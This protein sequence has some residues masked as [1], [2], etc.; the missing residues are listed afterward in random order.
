MAKRKSSKKTHLQEGWAIYLRTSSN[1][2]QNPKNSQDRQ[3]TRIMQ[4]LIVNSGLPVIAE[5]SDVETGKEVARPGY[6]KMLEDARDGKFSCIAVENTERFSRDD[7]EGLR[8]I[9]EL[10]GY[11]INVRFA[12]YASIDPLHHDQRLIIS[13]SFSIARGESERN[14][15]RSSGGIEAK[16]RTGMQTGKAVNGY[17]NV[18]ESLSGIDKVIEGPTRNTIKDDPE[19]WHVWREAWD[20]LLTARYSFKQICM[21]LH[22]RGYKRK[23]GR[24][25]IYIN[26]NGELADAS[27]TLSN[28][29]HN[30][31]YAGWVVSKT[32]GIF[33]KQIRGN[34]K[35]VVSD[36]EF[37]HFGI[38][39][40]RMVSS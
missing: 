16:Q 15:Q 19:T 34:W 6:Q 2:T 24:P 35:P 4:N 21:E 18:Q 1:E 37:E 28:I 25:F 5:Y 23:S 10:D 33:Y 27:A 14:S 20:L 36:E 22:A 12:D 17:I 30:P 31:F 7:V 9:D 8:A 40:A 13:M 29:F 32:N 3:R 38:T 11:G 39:T 26:K